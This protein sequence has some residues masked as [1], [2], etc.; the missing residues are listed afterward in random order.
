MDI[1]KPYTN[2]GR[3]FQIFTTIMVLL[4]AVAAADAV[5]MAITEALT[6]WMYIPQSENTLAENKELTPKELRERRLEE[7]KIE[8]MADG[9]IHLLYNTGLLSKSRMDYK[10]FANQF[11]PQPKLQIYDVNDN[12]IWEGNTPDIPYQY[13]GWAGD[14]SLDSEEGYQ[15]NYRESYYRGFDAGQL[16]SIQSFFPTL[17]QTLEL[18]LK[19]EHGSEA[20]RYYSSKDF[21]EGY[22]IKGPKIGYVSASGFSNSKTDAKPFGKFVT[23][24]NF[25]EYEPLK[26]SALWQTNKRL[27]QIDFNRRRVEVLFESNQA[28]IEGFSIKRCLPPRQFRSIAYMK[29]FNENCRPFIDCRTQDSSHHL[30]LLEPLSHLDIKLPADWSNWWQRKLEITAEKNGIFLRRSWAKAKPIPAFSRSAQYDNQFKTWWKEYRLKPLE[31]IDDIYKVNEDGTLHFLNSFSRIKSPRQFRPAEK[32]LKTTDYAQNFLREFSSPLYTIIFNK[33]EN[34][35]FNG[36]SNNN[37]FI[38]VTNTIL[39]ELHPNKIF[40]TLLVCTAFILVAFLHGFSRRTSIVKLI[41]WM[42]VVGLFNLAGLLAYLALN[43]THVIKCPVCGRKRGLEKDN[44]VQ[45]GS[46]LPLPQHKPT[47]LIMAN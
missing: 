3:P 34:E 40:P 28:D 11:P 6:Y 25:T 8:F 13:L 16:R 10:P 17:S 24:Q 36:T 5:I 45:C 26:N 7:S 37:G 33:Y 19:T 44:C 27:Y 38:S 46:P 43:H 35:I 29:V 12:L 32:I 20:W 4:F 21:L 31:M 22:K 42:F 41:L 15:N 2:L 30:I 18:N 47:D 23:V 14:N 9:N 1:R 39:L